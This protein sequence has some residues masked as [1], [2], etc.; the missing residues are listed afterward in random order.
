MDVRILD[1][2]VP[3]REKVQGIAALATSFRAALMA[4][5]TVGP[6]GSRPDF[7][8]WTQAI[9]AWSAMVRSTADICQA[10]N[11]NFN[12][13]RFFVACGLEI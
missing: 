8:A 13:T 10:Y 11:P 4:I 1:D 12:R 2:L 7:D 9:L 6:A 5:P 3:D